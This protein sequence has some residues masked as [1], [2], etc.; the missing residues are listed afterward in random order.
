M[1]K[2]RSP[3]A[4]RQRMGIEYAAL[5]PVLLAHMHKPCNVHWL[6]SQVICPLDPD[7]SVCTRD[8]QQHR[9][10]LQKVFVVM[11]SRGLISRVKHNVWQATALGHAARLA[12]ITPVPEPT[13]AIPKHT[14]E[15]QRLYGLFHAEQDSLAVSEARLATLLED[16]AYVKY[17]RLLAALEASEPHIASLE[18]KKAVLLAEIA[19]KKASCDALERDFTAVTPRNS[20]PLS[21]EQL[22]LAADLPALLASAEG[23]PP[24]RCRN[25]Q[26]LH[27]ALFLFTQKLV[28]TSRAL[29]T[30]LGWD[31]STASSA[32]NMLKSDRLLEAPPALGRYDRCDVLRVTSAGVNECYHRFPADSDAAQYKA[33]HPKVQ[34]A[35]MPVQ[36][37]VD[38]ALERDAKNAPA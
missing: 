12:A 32:V 29:A 22:W 6:T 24:Q 28:V 38:A 3:G 23:G 7:K 1:S 5:V 2:P 36:D 35:P 19:T 31:V 20:E 27:A 30:C 9:D 10:V 37:L 11:K 17:R 26:V 25:T 34:R 4:C 14:P 8:E 18:R 33:A 21:P 15:Q 16:E 13:M